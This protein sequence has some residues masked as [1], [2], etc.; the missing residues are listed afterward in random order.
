M[1]D[2]FYKEELMD[3]F[4]YPRH[5]KK[6]LDP[7]FSSEKN[8]LSCGDLIAVEGKVTKDKS[9]KFVIDAIGFS[10]SGCVISQATA[11]MLMEHCLGKTVDEVLSMNKDDVLS[12]TGLNLG[13]VR[14][15]CALLCL[16]ALS[17]ALSKY[18]GHKC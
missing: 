9:G 7:D 6:V 5:K 11:S 17:M 3:H 13:P 18:K 16:D 8:N 2:S 14:L 15:K 1:K 12:L 10:G 4:R